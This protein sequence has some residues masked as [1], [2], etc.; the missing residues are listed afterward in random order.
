[1][2]EPLSQGRAASGERASSSQHTTKTP[3]IGPRLSPAGGVVIGG[4][5]LSQPITQNEIALI[6]DAF[7]EHHIVVFREQVLSREQQFAFSLQF[8][9]SRTQFN[10]QIATQAIRGCSRDL[11]PGRERQPRRPVI[12]AGQQLQLAYG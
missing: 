3:S 11:Q 8:W 6:L 2:V 5:D 7:R 4:I 10:A 12:I 9:R 1:M